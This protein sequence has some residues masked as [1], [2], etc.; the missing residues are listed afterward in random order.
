M[1]EPI[2]RA[3]RT[4]QPPLPQAI[5]TPAQ[6]MGEL[7]PLQWLLF[8]VNDPSASEARRD[9][10]AIAAAP[11]VHPRPLAVGKKQRAAREA[12]EAGAGTEWGNDLD[13]DGHRRQ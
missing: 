7:S 3:R 10:C 5:V 8:V 2:T 11:Y 13:V 12:R 9:K 4:R 1:S 6:P